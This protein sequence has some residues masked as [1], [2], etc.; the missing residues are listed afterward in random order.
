[1]EGLDSPSGFC[2]VLFS[3][4]NIGRASPLYQKTCICVYIKCVSPFIY[5]HLIFECML[6]L[7]LLLSHLWLFMFSCPKIY[8]PFKNNSYGYSAQVSEAFCDWLIISNFPSITLY[9]H[10]WFKWTTQGKTFQRFGRSTFVMGG[11]TVTARF[12][13]AEESWD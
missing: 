13:Q 1:M 10:K 7:A 8:F 11:V 12:A 6:V 5:T 4:L 2:P 9:F 3:L